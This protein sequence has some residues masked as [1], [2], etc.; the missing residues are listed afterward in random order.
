VH[1]DRDGKG[2]GA[3]RRGRRSR[4]HQFPAPVIVSDHVSGVEVL[5]GRGVDKHFAVQEPMQTARRT[6]AV[7]VG[8]DGVGHKTSGSDHAV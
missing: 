8:S 7:I 3:S 2:T 5:P 1:G 6:I 4:R